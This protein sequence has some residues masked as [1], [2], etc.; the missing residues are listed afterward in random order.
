MDQEAGQDA[1]VAVSETG[2]AYKK[3]AADPKEQRR[4][5]LAFLQTGQF[6]EAQGD[7]NLPSRPIRSLPNY[8]G[9]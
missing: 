1:T 3:P 6:A 9:Y 7:S 4:L 8:T 2:L 5:G